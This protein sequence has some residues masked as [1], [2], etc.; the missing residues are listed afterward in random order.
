M[1]LAEQVEQGG[2]KKLK[3]EICFRKDVRI[4]RVGTER[5]S[6]L[7][8]PHKLHKITGIFVNY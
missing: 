4:K 2:D 1:R 3:T 6:L 5:T 8:H 7:P